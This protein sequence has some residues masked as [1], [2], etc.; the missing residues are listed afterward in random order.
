VRR[1]ANQVR[2]NAQLVDA[3]TG[4]HLW[5]ERYDRELKDLFALQDEVRQKIVLALKVKVTP[6]EQERFKR[7]PTEN[8]EA[9]DFLL[10]GVEYMYRFTKEANAQA[11]QMFERAR[12]LDSQYA[13]AYAWLGWTYA[14]EWIFR[15]R[16]DPK[17]L[18]Q[19]FEL[20]QRARTLDDSLPDAHRLL[21]FLYLHG[22]KQPE[23]AIAEIERTVILDPNYADGYAH[24]AEGLSFA[25]RPEEAIRVAQNAIRLN[26]RHPAWYLMELGIAYLMA[27]RVQEAIATHKQALRYDPNY[28]PAYMNLAFSYVFEWIWQLSQDPQTLER[29]F[30]A[31]QKVVALND[32]LPWGHT[33]LGEVYLWQKQHEKA[34]AAAERAIVLDPNDSDGYGLR[35]EILSF[36]GRPEE[37][38]EW[39]EKARRV[40]ALNP[41]YDLFQLGQV[42]CMSGRYEEAIAMLQRYLSH[43]PNLHAQLVLAIAYSELGRTEEAQAAA[44]EV[45]RISPNFSLEVWRQRVPYKDPAI[46]ERHITALRK[47]GLK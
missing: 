5:A 46:I 15:W 33:A 23:Q 34:L 39:A 6:E 21:G 38:L 7:F 12:A 42:Y 8:L 28:H 22:K 19:A 2:I 30:E 29:A 47:A 32:S 1:D 16:Q 9:Y 17:N 13:G 45:M 44:A 27:G 18:E 43:N 14:L 4:H 3:T 10:R 20:A 25:G 37:A 36:A 11:R 40:G 41:Y 24:L 31:A 26:P 35:A